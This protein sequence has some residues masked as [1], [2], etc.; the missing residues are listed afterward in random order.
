MIIYF[1]ATG[2]NRHIAQKLAGLTDDRYASML[3]TNEIVLEKGENLGIVTPVYFWAL[4]DIA[5]R[6]L[7][8]IKIKAG[9]ENY[10]YYVVSFGT[11]TGQT[12]S[13]VKK[14][15]RK[16]GLEL[17]AEYSVRMPD[18]W[19]VWFDLSDRDK[20]KRINRHADMNIDLIAAG[21][22]NR[23]EGNFREKKM[24]M[25]LVKGAQLL[26]QNAR[27]TSH[28]KLSS[29]KCIGCGLCEKNCPE[30]A[31]IMKLGK[32][33]W[34]KKKCTMCLGCLHRC[35]AFAISYENR[36]DSHGQYVHD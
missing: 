24:P 27:K 35:P 30:N 11:V 32:P 21:I 14:I 36:T 6:R 31:I 16:K 12:G 19:T 2:N 23:M 13:I 22:R 10:C 1:S 7:N 17:N 26:Y 33:E 28:L 9:G 3:E 8:E 18:T 5:R 25:P 20:V 34:T 29:D 15:L 4:P